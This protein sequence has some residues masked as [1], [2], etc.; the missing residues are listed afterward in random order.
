VPVDETEQP[1][2]PE[3]I[4]LTAEDDDAT[5]SVSNKLHLLE[6]NTL[7]G[8]EAPVQQQTMGAARIKIRFA[9]AFCTSSQ[10]PKRSPAPDASVEAPKDFSKVGELVKDP[11]GD[12]QSPASA[13]TES[14][15]SDL[16]SESIDEAL[17][18]DKPRL[19]GRKLVNY[20]PKQCGTETSGLCTIC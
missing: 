10:S 20:P 13:S 11:P 9:D 5:D 19:V 6:G 8:L 7:L 18:K 12:G 3:N 16:V 14:A 17:L 2:T 4:D 15:T 1:V